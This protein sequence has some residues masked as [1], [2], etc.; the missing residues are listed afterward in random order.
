MY[1]DLH[2]LNKMYGYT[3]EELRE[4]LSGGITPVEVIAQ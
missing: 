1:M 2:A 4:Q 3:Y